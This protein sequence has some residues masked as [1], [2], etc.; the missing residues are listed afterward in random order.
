VPGSVPRWVQAAYRPGPGVS[1]L[2]RAFLTGA[3]GF[4]GAN[5]A[6][7]LLADGIAIRALVREGSD[8]S[9]LEGLDI[10]V[11][12]GSLFDRERLRG[13]LEGCDACFHLAAAISHDDPGEIHRVNVEGTRAV[14]GAAADAGT[15]A[16]V[17]AS[18]IGTLCARKDGS[19]AR[20]TDSGI[21]EGASAYARSKLLSEDV[22]LELAGKGAPIVIAHIAA[23]IGPWDRVPTVTGRKVL[24]V[25]QGKDPNYGASS[26]NHVAV[27]DVARGLILAAEWGSPG[28]HYLLAREGGN[29]TRDEF[30]ALVARVAGIRPPRPGPGFLSLERY[31]GRRRRGPG[32]EPSLACDPSWSVRELGLP[33]TP[34]DV[35]FAEAVEWF[36]AHGALK[37]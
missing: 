5:L 21:P 32:T 2:R 13:D 28:K 22:A 7:A 11:R 23:P 1:G 29:L 31:F 20:E 3:T 8:R 10:E 24:R 34:L 37:E 6:R 26:I 15:A 4:V 17:H 27:K 25:L 35:A 30:V 18:T 36:R 19:P 16:L 14:L 12:F 9:S 33:Q